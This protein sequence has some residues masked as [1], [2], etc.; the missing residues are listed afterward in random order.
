MPTYPVT[1]DGRTLDITL[2]RPTRAIAAAPH[3]TR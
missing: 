2:E 1:I 3:H